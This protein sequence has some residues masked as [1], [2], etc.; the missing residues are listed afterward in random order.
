MTPSGVVLAVLAGRP[1]GHD[2]DERMGGLESE[3]MEWSKV[4]TFPMA[5]GRL[6]N[7]R[8]DYRAMNTGLSYGGGSVVSELILQLKRE[9]GLIRQ[10]RPGE[11]KISGKKNQ[12]AIAS[13][14]KSDKLEKLV[15]YIDCKFPQTV[16]CS[17]D[18]D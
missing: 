6:D 4:M 11:L 9:E 3:M 7:R 10:Q 15:R 2:W 13:L 16:Y 14:R 12:Q 1:G 17:L 8:G 5:N 18:W